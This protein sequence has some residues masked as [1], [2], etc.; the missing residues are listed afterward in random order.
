MGTGK[1]N[2]NHGTHERHGKDKAQKGS[3]AKERFNRY[4]VSGFSI[5][6]L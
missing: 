5:S 1:E 6:T 4:A 3:R 2:F